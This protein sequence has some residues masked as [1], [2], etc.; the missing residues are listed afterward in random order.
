MDP[1][2]HLLTRGVDTIYP[3]REALE[4]VLRSGKKL[5]LY[6]GFD[7]TGTQLHIGHGVAMR[8]LR[9]WQDLGHHV[10]FLIG[11][12][13]GQ[14]G[15]PSGKMKARGKFMSR[16][17][18]RA[19]AV[20]YVKQAGKIVRFDGENPVEILYNSDWLNALKL[21]D[22]LG[23]AQHFS[24]QQLIERDM[25]QERMKKGESINLREFLY[26]LLQGY[27][28]VAMNVDLEMGGTDQAFN[29]LAGRQLVS[30]MQG[31]EKFVMTVPLLSDAK[32]VK[33]GK[34]EGNVIGLTDPPN[35][36]FGKIMALGDDAVVPCFTLLTDVPETEIEA[37]KKNMRPIDFKKK[38]A[39]ELTKQFNTEK[40]AKDAQ[41]EFETRFQK[42]DISNSNIPSVSLAAVSSGASVSEAMVTFK[43]AS[44]KSEAKRLIDQGAVK[45]NGV[46]ITLPKQLLDAIPGIL[47]VGR[48]AV[49]ITS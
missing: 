18:L 46:L 28:S 33:I 38:L 31:R 44:S 47:E 6:Q 41:K 27:D 21:V 3:S 25:F 10:I 20:D 26:P 11:D 24:V 12:G 37:M 17:E 15:D 42:G 16:E 34:T 9:E 43:L 39:F 8:K 7:P 2:T 23:I 19:N 13:T 45:Y 35:D 36:F 22:I 14:A 32:G 4:K 49:K 40:E 1:I 29:M 30:A 48:K 5:R